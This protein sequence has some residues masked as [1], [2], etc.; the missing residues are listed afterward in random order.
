MKSDI[1]G[2]AI[3]LSS[4]QKENSDAMT[5]IAQELVLLLA[6]IDTVL[7]T[8]ILVAIGYVVLHYIVRLK[9]KGKFVIAFYLLAFLTTVCQI[10]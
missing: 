7:L 3:T 8:L 5:L 10:V 9:I 4:T 6:C 1:F 2:S